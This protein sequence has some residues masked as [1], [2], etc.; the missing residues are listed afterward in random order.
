MYSVAEKYTLEQI[1]ELEALYPGPYLVYRVEEKNKVG[2]TRQSIDERRK[3]MERY[4]KIK[5]SL[6]KVLFETYDLLT[7]AEKEREM[8]AL[9]GSK[10]E[11]ADYVN[12]LKRQV[13]SITKKVRRKAI[14][15]TDQTK[16]WTASAK[17]KAS[18]AK[19]SIKVRVIASEVLE[20]KWIGKRG[21]PG[22]KKV[23]TKSKYFRTFN[24]LSE[25]S[26][27]FLKK[28]INITPADI[29]HILKPEFKCNMRSGYTFKYT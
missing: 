11:T 29:L 13:T 12:D 18:Q 4:Y 28:G 2:C 15:N 9:N 21:Q 14:D 19:E 24:S 1:Q 23:I 25:A 5:L 22:C 10:W 17:R 20:Q 27:Y 16:K 8:K 7:A 6:P 3:Q 26:K